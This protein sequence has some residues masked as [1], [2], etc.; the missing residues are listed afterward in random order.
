M[1]V[2]VTSIVGDTI[3]GRI[4]SP[5]QVVRGYRYGQPYALL[6]GELLDWTIAKPD[7]SEE[8]NVVGKFLDGYRPPLCSDSTRTT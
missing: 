2:A 5:I 6:E 1:F 4:S 7:G 3:R 8:G